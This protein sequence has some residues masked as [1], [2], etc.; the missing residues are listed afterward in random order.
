VFV[1]IFSFQAFV[2]KG[3]HH[4]LGNENFNNTRNNPKNIKRG[5]ISLATFDKKF[6]FSV[7]MFI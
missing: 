4:H 2:L 7:L 6:S 1:L 5:K 3:S